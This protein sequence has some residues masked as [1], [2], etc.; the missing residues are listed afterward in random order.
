MS[1]GRVEMPA[2]NMADRE[3]HDHLVSD[4]PIARG[5]FPMLGALTVLPT[6]RRD[7]KERCAMNSTMYFSRGVAVIAALE[8]ERGQASWRGWG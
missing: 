5:Q 4:A 3:D 6:V 8:A 7:E 2:G 1:D